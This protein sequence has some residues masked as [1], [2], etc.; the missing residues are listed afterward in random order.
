MD[1]GAGGPGGPGGPGGG[2]GKSG[3]C[4]VGCG[5]LWECLWGSLCLCVLCAR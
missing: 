5:S 4:V 3:P 1:G 2:G